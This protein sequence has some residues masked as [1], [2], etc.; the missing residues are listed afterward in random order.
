M[1]IMKKNI[2][3]LQKKSQKNYK[4][5]NKKTKKVYKINIKRKKISKNKTSKNKM[6][7]TYLCCFLLLASL[8]TKCTITDNT[9]YSNLSAVTTLTSSEAD[10]IIYSSSPFNSPMNWI[11]CNHISENGKKFKWSDSQGWISNKSRN[12]KI[13]SINGN[14]GGG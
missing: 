3:K 13:K 12:R 6:A 14:R 5:G 9:D 2:K 4:T 11:H 7:V 8:G 1:K 10:Y